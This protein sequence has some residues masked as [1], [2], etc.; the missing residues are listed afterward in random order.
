MGLEMLLEQLRPQTVVT[1]SR[2]NF[3]DFMAAIDNQKKRNGA[4]IVFLPAKD[5][6]YEH[7]LNRLQAIAKEV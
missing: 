5:F 2:V 6:G 3:D 7:G 1:S 4:E